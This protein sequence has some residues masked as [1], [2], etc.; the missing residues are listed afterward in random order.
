MSDKRDDHEH[1]F[2]PAPNTVAFCRVGDCT[3]MRTVDAHGVLREL[4]P[5]Q[6]T[7]ATLIMWEDLLVHDVGEI[8][9]GDGGKWARRV[10]GYEVPA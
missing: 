4:T 2:R 5:E 10:L 1:L 3:E 8:I 6:R 9:H 7:Q